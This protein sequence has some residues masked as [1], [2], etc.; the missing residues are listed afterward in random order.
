[1]FAE[2]S[3]DRLKGLRDTLKSFN[4]PGV[5]ILRFAYNEKR[6]KL[7]KRYADINHYPINTFAQTTTHDTETLLGYLNILS[8]EEKKLLS[9]N[10]NVRFGKDNKTFAKRLR[11]AVVSSSA[12]TVIIPIQ[13]WLLSTERINIPG[14]EKIVGDTN[15]QYRIPV[16]IE[17]LPSVP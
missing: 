3:G 4:I 14:T 5:R 13:D 8:V 10:C 1:L 11:T 7:T 9:V 17:N 15:W 6:R 12:K 16:S 2:D